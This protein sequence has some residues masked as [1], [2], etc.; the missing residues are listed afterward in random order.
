MK[1]LQ[2][3]TPALLLWLSPWITAIAYS[4]SND[5]CARAVT[6]T[7]RGIAFASGAKTDCQNFM[8]QTHTVTIATSAAPT[9]KTIPTYASECSG[10][11]RYSS[12]CSC[13]GIT[14]STISREDQTTTVTVSASAVSTSASSTSVV[15]TTTVSTTTAST[16]AVPTGGYQPAIPS[17]YDQCVFDPATG[18]EFELYTPNGLAIVNKDG[19][20][21]ETDD[22]SIPVDPFKFSHPS[23]APNGLYDIVLNAGGQT[24]YLAVFK[25]GAVGFVDTSS[26]GQSY[27]GTDN[28]YITT[29]WS[30]ECDGLTS[31]GIVGGESFDFIVTDN[32]DLIVLTSEQS[33][34]KNRRDIPVPKGF[35]VKPK[36]VE[37][38]PGTKCSNPAQH[39]TS[40]SPPVPLTSNGCGPEGIGGWLVPDGDFTDACNFH[41]VCWSDCSSTFAGC[42]TDFYYR[43][44]DICNARYPAGK[45]RS[46]CIS[47]AGIYHSAVSSN[48]GAGVFTDT[49]NQYCDCVCND[50]K[51]T[52]CQ[53]KCVDTKTDPQHCGSCNFN[54]A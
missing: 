33:K 51:L 26:N 43:M 54:A 5:N 24:L 36:E 9:A 27:V 28:Q 21:V 48:Y 29:I 1:A 38:P 14:A 35:Y 39:A 32:G 45:D 49:I 40:K 17:S 15:S 30:V 18:G 6:G 3:T 8:I 34:R 7:R 23:G 50:S 53:D 10:T 4:C 37:T 46:K 52:T 25:T 19:K 44:V 41:D 2:L 13:W 11:S 31:A 20:A 47:R 22:A 16:S 42:N 12:A